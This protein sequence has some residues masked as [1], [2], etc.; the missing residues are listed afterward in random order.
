VSTSLSLAPTAPL[1][2][3]PEAV[4]GAGDPSAGGGHLRIDARVVQKLA[5]RAANEVDGVSQAAV[6]PI[7][8]AIHHPVPASTPPDQ[9]A[10]DLDLSVCVDYPRSLRVVVEELAAHV[11]RRVE[12]L[13][14]RPV[15]RVHVRVRGLGGDD[16][17]G[18]PRVR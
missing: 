1:A 11:S 4:P 6:A 17:A 16:G 5:A 12:Q 18:H 3:A 14:G 9:L 8:R 2:A 10:V 15:G 7:G 13:T